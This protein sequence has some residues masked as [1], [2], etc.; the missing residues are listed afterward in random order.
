[1]NE[2]CSRYPMESHMLCY[3]K[4]MHVVSQEFNIIGDQIHWTYIVQLKKNKI[5]YMQNVYRNNIFLLVKDIYN[6]IKQ[7]RE[8]SINKN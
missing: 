7:V 6:Y 4:K 8:V 1:M 3:T 2:P 5:V